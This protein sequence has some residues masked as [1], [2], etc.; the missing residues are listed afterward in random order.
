MNKVIMLGNLTRDPVLRHTGAG[1]AVCNFS[2]AHNSRWTDAAGEKKEDVCYVDFTAW[3]KLAETIGQ[4]CKR[5][6]QL[7]VEGRLKLETYEHDNE[8]R[9]KLIVTVETFQFTGAK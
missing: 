2:L 1:K 4:R 5:G 6:S 8:E 3:G 7:L 9:S